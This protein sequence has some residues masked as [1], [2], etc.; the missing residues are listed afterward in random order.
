MT[1]DEIMQEL[2]AIREEY[3]A[4]HEYDLQSIFEDAKKHEGEGGRRV[5]RAQPK[6]ISPMQPETGARGSA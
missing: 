6:R 2:R 1:E 4:E 3:A 5:L